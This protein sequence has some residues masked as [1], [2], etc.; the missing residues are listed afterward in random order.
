[1]KDESFDK[2]EF[3]M[4]RKHLNLKMNTEKLIEHDKD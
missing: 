1:M 2:E 4:A 3:S